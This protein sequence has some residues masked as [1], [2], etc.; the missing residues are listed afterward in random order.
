MSSIYMAMPFGQ[1]RVELLYYI[2]TSW[3]NYSLC[4]SQALLAR[5]LQ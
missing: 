3:G 4:I 1:M 2:D 5:L